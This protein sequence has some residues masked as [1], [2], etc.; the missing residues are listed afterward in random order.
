MNEL[1]VSDAANLLSSLILICPGFLI[2]YFRNVFITGRRRSFSES[3]VDF[4]VIS[5]AY[6]S[7]VGIAF[8][9]F[10][11]TNLFISFLFL[12]LLPCVI[13]VALG[14]FYQN[15][16]LDWI[17]NKLKINPVHPAS[18]AWDFAFG[19]MKKAC[20]IIVTTTDGR[21]IRGWY[22]SSSGV[23]SDLTRRDIYIQDVRDENFLRLESDGRKRGMWISEIEIGYVEFISDQQE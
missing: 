22:N 4:L 21:K 20:W 17:Y 18:T 8:L 11:L 2:S 13:G 6:Y 19:R 7:S 16:G 3:A 12:F 10:G 9:S 5:A 23:S 14:F 15:D 1:V